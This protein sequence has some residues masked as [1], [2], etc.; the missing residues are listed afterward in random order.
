VQA[1]IRA[2][3]AP[4]EEIRAEA[5]REIAELRKLYPSPE[6]TALI[7][8]WQRIARRARRLL[9]KTAIRPHR[10]AP[11]KRPA[12]RQSQRRRRVVRGRSRRC[13]RDEGEDG[14]RART[15]P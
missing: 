8:R 3:E 6:I 13:D 2:Y 10:F 4:V 5:R 11:R 7:R 9:A 12:C 15:E 14:D 1:A